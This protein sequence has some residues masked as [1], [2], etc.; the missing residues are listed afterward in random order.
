MPVEDPNDLE[1][2]DR[3]I[4]IN[5]LKRQAEELT[6]GEMVSGESDD[7]PPEMAEQFWEQ[8]VE[9]ERAPLT[10][11]FAKLEERGVVMTPPEELDD[12]AV[13]AKLW[14]V[15]NALAEM[16]VFLHF[17]NHMSDR[18]L[19]E[20][21]W[22]DALRGERPDLPFSPDGA[23]HYDFMT[24]SDEDIDAS[25]KYSADEEERRVWMRQFPDYNMPDHEDPPYDRDMN[26]PG[27]GPAE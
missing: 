10:T 1:R 6:G 19:Y 9:Y 12:G 18:E 3:E 17:T 27:A 23:W 16:R 4:H 21:L 20:R 25:M 26:L 15:I 7:M 24:G 11:D 13:H 5:E 2:V 8:V 14:E 22:G